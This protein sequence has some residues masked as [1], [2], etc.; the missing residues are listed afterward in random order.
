[1]TDRERLKKL[2]TD[3][4]DHDGPFGL[5]KDGKRVGLG[6]IPKHYKRITIPREDQLRLARLG[7]IDIMASYG[8]PLFFTQAVIAGAILSGEYDTVGIVTTSQ[9][10]KSWLMGRIALRLAYDGHPVNVA[11]SVG[12]LTDKIMRYCLSAASTANPEIKKAL[13]SETLKKVDR[14]DQSL[15]KTRLSFPGRGRGQ[16]QAITLGD[17]FSN[18][19]H[20]K[21][22]GEGGAFIV[23][24]AAFVGEAS[25]AEIGRREFS[26]IDGSI[27]PLIMISNPHNPGYFY[28]FITGDDIGKRELVIWSDALTIAQEGRKTVDEILSSDF[29]KRQDT[30]QRYLL[31]ELPT[32][33]D[34]MF[35]S[36]EVREPVPHEGYT[37]SVLGID[38]AYKGKDSIRIA[39]CDIEGTKLYIPAV[40]E[41]RKTEWVD[42][43]T[44]QAIIRQIAKT[45][46]SLGCAMCCVDIGFGVWLLEGLMQ[47]GVNAHGVNFGAGPT[48][49]RVKDKHYAAVNAANMRAEMHIDLAELIE[50]KVCA[51]SPQAYRQ[52]EETLPLVTS[53]LK[54]NNKIQVVPKQEI[55]AKLGHSPDAFDAVLLAVHAAILYSDGCVTYLTD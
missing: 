14:L 52:I 30:L 15:S 48:K 20:N 17:T 43:V 40:E 42:G 39:Q 2:L 37:V 4:D 24:E 35:E 45:Y 51:F 6:N 10:G 7:L 13:T 5:T 11:A 18:L 26:S 55:K 19:S 41:I 1:M 8:S 3:A 54:H 32:K 9:Y 50:N 49:S 34:G 36:P 21:A 29:A 38:A 22:I 25:M 23:D 27:E 44:S 31:C 53:E 28:D 33:G 12:D 46:H 47:H 16:V